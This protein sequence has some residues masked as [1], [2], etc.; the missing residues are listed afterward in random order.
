M[1][2]RHGVKDTSCVE[3]FGLLL[4]VV[5]GLMETFHLVALF[6]LMAVQQVWIVTNYV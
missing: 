6:H 3:G 1:F 4:V 2:M 5:V